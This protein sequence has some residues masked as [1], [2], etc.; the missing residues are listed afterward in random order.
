M[1]ALI[2]EHNSLEDKIKAFI[3]CVT[4]ANNNVTKMIFSQKE[5]KRAN[6]NLCVYVWFGLTIKY[7]HVPLCYLQSSSH[8]VFVQFGAKWPYQAGIKYVN[9]WWLL[10]IK[11]SVNVFIGKSCFASS[12]KECPLITLPVC[13]FMFLFDRFNSFINSWSFNL[14]TS[15]LDLVFF[16][17]VQ[18]PHRRCWPL[19]R[20]VLLG[21]FV[22]IPWNLSNL[23]FKLISLSI[24]FPL[25]RYQWVE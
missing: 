9:R 12:I 21:A 25:K 16:V 4:Y 20:L 1:S 15:A 6:P 19:S 8:V 23:N 14:F 2:S 18:V 24:L 7:L 3:D 10:I 11:Y 13:S 22:S 17:C 5:R